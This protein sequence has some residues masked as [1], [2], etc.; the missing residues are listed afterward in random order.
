MKTIL[1]SLFAI[2]TLITSLAAVSR[3]D[4]QAPGSLDALDAN[5]SGGFVTT[6]AVQPDGKIIIG[7]QFTSVLGV[8]RSN[9]ARLNADGTLDTGFDPGERHRL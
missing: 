9:I 7:G 8:A 3:A 5:V 1:R 2:L 6:T 4:A